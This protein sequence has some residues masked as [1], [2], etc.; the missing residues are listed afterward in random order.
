MYGRNTKENED[1][2]GSKRK[3]FEYNNDSDD[4]CQI[5]DI[6]WMWENA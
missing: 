5:I 4:D 1:E 6:D 2:K 3:Q